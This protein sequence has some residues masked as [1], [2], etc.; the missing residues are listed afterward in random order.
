MRVVN[1]ANVLKYGGVHIEHPSA[2]DRGAGAKS[3]VFIQLWTVGERSRYAPLTEDE[4]VGL[5]A[6]AAGHLKT[7]RKQ[8]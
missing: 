4:L 8:R 5:I 6:E 2:R 3:E 7:L 1:E